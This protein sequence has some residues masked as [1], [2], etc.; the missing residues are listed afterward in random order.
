[1]ATVVDVQGV[2]V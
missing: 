2:N 1:M